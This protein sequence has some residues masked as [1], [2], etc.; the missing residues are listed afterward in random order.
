MVTMGLVSLIFAAFMLYRRRDVA[1]GIAIDVGGPGFQ[2]MDEFD[3]ETCDA[4]R[5]RLAPSGRIVMNVMVA[6]DIDPTPTGSPPD[7]PVR[8]C[9]HGS[10]MSKASRTAMPSSPAYPRRRWVHGPHSIA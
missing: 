2:F 9:G 8:N 1:D 10:S 6:N 3:T 5:A 4:I 7:L